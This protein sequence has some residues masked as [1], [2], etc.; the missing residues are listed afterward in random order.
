MLWKNRAFYQ[1][2]NNKGRKKKDERKETEFQIFSSP[3]HNNQINYYSGRG[4]FFSNKN[5]AEY[6]YF[7]GKMLSI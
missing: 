6:C 3:F 7:Q 2:N 1:N 5:R 4:F